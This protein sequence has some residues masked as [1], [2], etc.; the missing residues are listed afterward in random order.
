[1]TQP[2]QDPAEPAGFIFSPA[3]LKDRRERGASAV[4]ERIRP[5]LAIV[6]DESP[7][8]HRLHRMREDADRGVVNAGR[9][10]EQSIARSSEASIF[11]AVA[12]NYPK[13]I[14]KTPRAE[15]AL[16]EPMV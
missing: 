16:R 6:R 1:M 14:F 8:G 4:R 13:P 12:E 5:A 15:E 3:I 9:C 2:G 11:A 7:D 10:A